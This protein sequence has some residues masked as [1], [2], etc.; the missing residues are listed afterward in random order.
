MQRAYAVLLTGLFVLGV[1][2]GALAPALAPTFD[3]IRAAMEPLSNP[4]VGV[5]VLG[6]IESVVFVWGPLLFGGLTIL[7]VFVAAVKYRGTGGV[8]P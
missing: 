1:H 4:V 6:T 8:R 5:G 7:I 3:S 2:Y